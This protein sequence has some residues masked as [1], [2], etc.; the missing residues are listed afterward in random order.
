MEVE[1]EKFAVRLK[2]WLGDPPLDA[3]G[4]SNLIQQVCRLSKGLRLLNLSKTS[5]TSKGLN[6]RCFLSAVFAMLIFLSFIGRIFIEGCLLSY[7][8]SQWNQFGIHLKRCVRR[9][10]LWKNHLIGWWIDTFFWFLVDVNGMMWV[11]PCMEVRKWFK[12]FPVGDWLQRKLPLVK[13][14]GCNHA[15]VTNLV[16]HFLRGIQSALIF[17]HQVRVTVL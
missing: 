10:I 17:D 5:L 14:K 1:W 12:Y 11:S 13:F 3:A 15:A 9:P 16:R 2:L 8:Y 4:V 6:H 7:I